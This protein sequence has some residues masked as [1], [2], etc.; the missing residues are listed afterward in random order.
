[1]SSIGESKD[2]NRTEID[3]EEGTYNLDRTRY[4]ELPLPGTMVM[5]T[6]PP[7]ENPRPMTMDDFKAAIAQERTAAAN[8]SYTAA[9]RE[10]FERGKS[11]GMSLGLAQGYRS[12][13]EYSRTPYTPQKGFRDYTSVWGWGSI[14]TLGVLLGA[15][16]I[17]LS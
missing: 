5:M 12:I 10:G 17:A 4:V 7:G 3:T 15:A 13:R 11:Q 9:W 6:Y 1:M 8:E 2:A 16:L 14:I